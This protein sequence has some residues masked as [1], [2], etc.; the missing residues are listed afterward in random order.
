MAE[1]WLSA[2]WKGCVTNSWCA[3]GG[4][5][6]A[7]ARDR[8]AAR[9]LGGIIYEAKLGQF[10][11]A[12]YVRVVMASAPL[13]VQLLALRTSVTVDDY[14]E[15]AACRDAAL[16]LLTDDLC[17]EKHLLRVLE[18]PRESVQHTKA[19]LDFKKEVL[20]YSA[21]EHVFLAKEGYL[22][23]IRRRVSHT[24]K[25]LKAPIRFGVVQNSEGD[26]AG[27]IEKPPKVDV[28]AEGLHA[29]RE[30]ILLSAPAGFGKSHIIKNVLKPVLEG[31]YGKKGCMDHGL[32]WAGCFGSRW[33][34][35]S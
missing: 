3:T 28:W 23:R 9:D 24:R 20:A 18:L 10:R 5:R 31:M 16:L 32:H 15:A 12:V 8:K 35:N 34:D 11:S 22:E 25:E 21:Q 7:S 33:H 29:R 27:G 2:D 13:T 6:E 17:P 14:K 4:I 1:C 19:V 26:L 30:N